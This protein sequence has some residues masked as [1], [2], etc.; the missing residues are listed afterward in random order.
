MNNSIFKFPTISSARF[1][2]ERLQNQGYTARHTHSGYVVVEGSLDENATQVILESLGT[3]VAAT[4]V[5]DLSL[6]KHA[7]TGQGK[8]KLAPKTEDPKSPPTA[9]PKTLKKHGNTSATQTKGDVE[10]AA[11]KPAEPAK[12]KV[13]PEGKKMLNMQQLAYETLKKL[14]EKY[15][16]KF[17]KI[18]KALG[19]KVKD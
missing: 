5:E 1:V 10:E 18:A 2:V 3:H 12:D 4:G 14:V 9:N 11:E 17:P 16:K 6:A 19:F 13:S 7:G 8:K 15:P